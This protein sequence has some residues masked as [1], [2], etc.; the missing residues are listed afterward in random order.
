MSRLPSALPPIESGL[1]GVVF[2][3]AH[4][5][6]AHSGISPYFAVGYAVVGLVSAPENGFHLSHPEIDIKLSLTLYHRRAHTDL[7]A[8]IVVDNLPFLTFDISQSVVYIPK[9]HIVR[10]G[11]FLFHF[12]P[13]KPNLTP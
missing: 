4:A 1:L 9:F 7:D 8:P 3:L 11:F 6:E 12:S 5:I 10:N 2:A 13:P